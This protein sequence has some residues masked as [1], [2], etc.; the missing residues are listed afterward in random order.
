MINFALQ[1]NYVFYFLIFRLKNIS[2]SRCLFSDFF[3]LLLS[4][5]LNEMRIIRG[6]L[7]PS[8]FYLLYFCFIF[9]WLI[10]LI[11]NFY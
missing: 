4:S 8:T 9:K 1:V 7:S 11:F 5:S 6:F 2:L 3:K 10:M